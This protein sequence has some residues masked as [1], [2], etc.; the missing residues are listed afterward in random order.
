V[1]HRKDKNP[2]ISIEYACDVQSLDIA[3]AT[4]PE[5]CDRGEVKWSS[6]NVR[7]WL[8]LT[9]SKL[10]DIHGAMDWEL[11]ELVVTQFSISKKAW[12]PVASIELQLEDYWDD[13]RS[14]GKWFT[15]VASTGEG[16]LIPRLSHVKSLLE[17]RRTIIPQLYISNL[18]D[19]E[20]TKQIWRKRNFVVAF[21]TK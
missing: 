14:S 15:W 1:S 20:H 17:E 7:I 19:I 5:G 2:I 18:S 8:T 6:G 12:I 3:H 16:P 21:P 4:V 11:W 10:I 9:N 13:W